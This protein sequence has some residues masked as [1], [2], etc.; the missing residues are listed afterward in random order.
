MI[1][2]L[3][4]AVREQVRALSARLQQTTPRERA[5]LGVLLL[6]ALVILPLAA[7]DWRV[8]QEDRYVEALEDRAQ[9][10]RTADAA[11]RI[12]TALDDKLALEDMQTWGFKASNVDVARVMIEDA[13]ARAARETEL[14]QVTIATDNEIEAI[15]PTDWLGAE[16]QADLRWSTLFNFL[17][18]VAA[19]PQGF[20]V[21]A[22]SYELTAQPMR[23]QSTPDQFTPISGKVRVKLAFPVVLPD[24]PEAREPA[25]RLNRTSVG[26]RR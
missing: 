20:R 4:A 22:F 17:D 13:L 3:K 6:G 18:R 1:A 9:A 2:G 5:L 12:R 21:V 25:D 10:R 16:V 11:K 8:G 26:G 19:M 23:A 15:G 14:T 7:A 24:D